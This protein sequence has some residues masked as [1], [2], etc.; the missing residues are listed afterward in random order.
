M[1]LV[2]GILSYTQS[3]GCDLETACILDISCIA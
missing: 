2:H 1:E 3:I